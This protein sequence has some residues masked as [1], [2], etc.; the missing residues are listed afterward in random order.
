VLLVLTAFGTGAVL[1]SVQEPR[2]INILAFPFLGVIAWNLLVYLVLLLAWL[3]R[4]AGRTG[5][6]VPQP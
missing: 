2:R 1:A 6:A 4:A 3:R 5:K